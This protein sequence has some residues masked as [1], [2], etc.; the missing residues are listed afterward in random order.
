MLGWAAF[1][2]VVRWSD[3]GA[4]RKDRDGGRFYVVSVTRGKGRINTIELTDCWYTKNEERIEISSE[5]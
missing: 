4:Q 5:D 3:V 2:S 1:L